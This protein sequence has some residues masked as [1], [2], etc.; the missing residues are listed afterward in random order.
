MHPSGREFEIDLNYYEN[1]AF[2]ACWAQLI[3]R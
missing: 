2:G 1:D 3:E